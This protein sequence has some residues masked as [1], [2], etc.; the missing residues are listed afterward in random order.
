MKIRLSDRYDFRMKS[1]G[2][3]NR[4]KINEK[5]DLELLSDKIAS[6]LTH[7]VVFRWWFCGWHCCLRRGS[8]LRSGGCVQHCEVRTGCWVAQVCCTEAIPWSKGNPVK[9]HCG[10][11]TRLLRRSRFLTCASV[12]FCCGFASQYCAFDGG[13]AV[14]VVA[15]EGACAIKPQGMYSIARRKKINKDCTSELRRS[16]LLE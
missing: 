12:L 11:G 2:L 5:F 16:N 3:K 6:V 8:L 13:L 7:K 4:C 9:K 1:K 10:N 14:G 15:F